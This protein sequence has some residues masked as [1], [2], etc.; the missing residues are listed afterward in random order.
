MPV[1]ARCTRAVNVVCATP[2]GDHITICSL[3]LGCCHS[4]CIKVFHILGVEFPVHEDTIMLTFLSFFFLLCLQM[5]LGAGLVV[6]QEVA[7]FFLNLSLTSIFIFPFQNHHCCPFL[8]FVSCIVFIYLFI[9]CFCFGYI[10]NLV[11]F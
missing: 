8:L 7:L 2:G 1:S 3:L 6:Y 4:L 11:F 5:V 10:L 9:Y